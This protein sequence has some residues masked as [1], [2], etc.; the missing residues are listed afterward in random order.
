MMSMDASLLMNTGD[1][2]YTLETRDTWIADS[3]AST[4]MCNSNKGMFNCLPTPNQYIKVGN[5]DQLHVLKKAKRIAEL[6]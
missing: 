1:R 6:Y 5:S 2:Y 3:R 4:H